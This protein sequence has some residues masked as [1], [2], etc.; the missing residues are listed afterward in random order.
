MPNYRS[1]FW[2]TTLLALVVVAL[3]L[4]LS[5]I[6]VSA[7][8]TLAL[9][10]V[11]ILLSLPF[12]LLSSLASLAALGGMIGLHR[13]ALERRGQPYFSH[14][15]R[16]RSPGWLSKLR[17]RALNQRLSSQPKPRF[18]A[19]EWARV[20]P[21]S[22][23]AATLDEKG[24]L[25]GLPFMPEMLRLCGSHHRVFRR[26][27][28]FHDYFTPGSTGLRR[29]RDAVMLND[30][31]CG[32]EA[33]D[34]CQA[35]C[36]F[37]WKEAWLEPVNRPAVD[38]TPSE[39]PYGWQLYEFSRRSLPE[40]T[41]YSCQMTELPRASSPMR[42]NDPRHYLRDFWC[43]NVRFYPFVKAVAL[44]LFNL[45]QK[46]IGGPTAPYREA[47]GLQTD[48][49]P[50]LNLRPRDIV[51]VKSKQEIEKTL[52]KSRNRG[53]WF[54]GE[55]HRFCGG[56]FRVSQRVETIVDEASGRMLT[57]K[58]P[59]IVLDGVSATG[60]YIGL[61]PQNELIYWREVWL[62]RVSNAP[63]REPIQAY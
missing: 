26:A 63:R 51:R 25:D 13:D 57:M 10:L 34:G 50:P 8:E 30:L 42:F 21:F 54:D 37:I 56:E 29:L 33:H 43:G 14:E 49:S 35:G 1:S 60:E 58:Y 48:V 7:G 59:C 45:V 19:G 17:R 52:K 11:W 53:L 38:D 32:G 40:G 55:M 47:G 22:E 12:F 61:C 5:I 6:L 16:E 62:E 27:E 2:K 39:T 3:S 9:R 4:I 36:Q 28:K 24:C 18:W 23:I 20:K 46:K 44:A 31:R 41:C 15:P